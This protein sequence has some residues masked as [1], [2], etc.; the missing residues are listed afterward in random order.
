MLI[1]CP[2]PEC[3]EVLE[4]PEGTAGEHL[5]CPACSKQFLAP[6]TDAPTPRSKLRAERV[7][8]PGKPPT[9]RIP[10]TIVMSAA[11]LERDPLIG[12][13]LGGCLIE[14]K[15]GQGGMGAVYRARHVGLDIDVAVK[16]VPHYLVRRSPQFIDRFQREAR[17]AARLD[18]PNIVKVHNVG[19]DHG[20]HFMVMEFVD[21][22]SLRERL[23]REEELDL[24]TALS[25]FQQVLQALIASHGK[26]IIH[27]DL[28][29]DN[30]LLK[31][32]AREE[33][34]R[35]AKEAPPGGTEPRKTLLVAKLA[36]LGL[37]KV[38]DSESE[39]FTLS[40]VM[41]GTVDYMSPE[42]A[43]DAKSVDERA[44]IY[45]LGC[46]L[47]SML[48]GKKPFPGTTMMQV[49][50]KHVS[51]PFPDILEV[52]PDAPKQIN[53]ML[54]KMTAKQPADRYQ[55]VAEVMDALGMATVG[56]TAEFPSVAP[57]TSAA[58][59]G[60]LCPNC[61]RPYE[62]DAK[63]CSK[64]GRALFEECRRCGENVRAGAA[65]CIH[66]GSNLAEE[67]SIVDGLDLARSLLKEKH[68]NDALESAERIL[69]SDPERVEAQ[70]IRDEAQDLLDRVGELKNAAEVAEEAGNFEDARRSLEKA[71]ELFPGDPELQ[72]VLD[73]LPERARQSDLRTKLVEARLALE[74]QR[75]RTAR[76]LYQ[77]VLAETPGHE[78]ATDGLHACEEILYAIADR[79][80]ELA[81]LLEN[82][83]R[84]QARALCESILEM[85]RDD[86]EAR[87]DLESLGEGEHDQAPAVGEPVPEMDR[88]DL[89]PRQD[90]EVVDEGPAPVDEALSRARVLARGKKWD[91]AVEAW[92]LTLGLS[93]QHAE[94][95]LK[96]HEAR[97]ARDEFERLTA[98]ARRIVEMGDFARA[99]EA[100]LEA[101]KA[102]DWPEGVRILQKVR[103]QGKVVEDRLRGAQERAGGRDWDAA[104]EAFDDVIRDYPSHRDALEGLHQAR[105]ARDVFNDFAH[106]ALQLV[107]ARSLADAE[108]MLRKAHRAGYW[109]ES[110]RLLKQIQDD[111]ARV[112]ALH[113]QAQALIERGESA[114]ALPVL[115]E[116]IRIWP[117]HSACRC[118]QGH[119]SG[120][121]DVLRPNV[122]RARTLLQ[123]NR[124]TSAIEALNATR[125]AGSS[126]D[127][128]E[129]LRQA[130]GRISSSREA[131]AQAEASANDRK[132]RE[133]VKLFEKARSYDEESVS[134]EQ[135]ADARNL[136]APL[137]GQ[138]ELLRGLADREHFEELLREARDA[139]DVGVDDEIDSLCRLAEERLKEAWKKEL[140][141]EQAALR[142]RTKIRKRPKPER[143]AP[144][145]PPEEEPEPPKELTE[146][147]K[148]ARAKL[149]E[150]RQYAARKEWQKTI[151]T[152]EEAL[153]HDFSL[154]EARELVRKAETALSR[155]GIGKIAL[156]VAAAVLA[157]VV[158]AGAILAYRS[159]REV[160][161]ERIAA[162][163]DTQM[164]RAGEKIEAADALFLQAGQELA[165]VRSEGKAERADGAK[166][167]FQ[168]AGKA[169]SA[170]LTLL[171]EARQKVENGPLDEERRKQ[172]DSAFQDTSGKKERAAA[173]ARSSE[174]LLHAFAMFGEC[175]AKGRQLIDSKEMEPGLKA[176]GQALEIGMKSQL[177]E[178]LLKPV[179]EA[180]TK[181]GDLHFGETLNR[182]DALAQAHEWEPAR[183]A[184]AEA[185]RIATETLENA[186]LAEN[187]AV[188]VAAMEAARYTE[189][190]KSGEAHQKAGEWQDARL[191][192]GEAVTLARDVLAREDLVARAQELL[193]QLN[194]DQFNA[195]IQQGDAH[196]KAKRWDEAEAAFL[197]A[198][199]AATEALVDAS[200]ASQA[201]K[202]VEEVRLSRAAAAY[203][204]KLRDGR[205]ELAAGLAKIK[206]A[207]V[208]Q[209]E[210]DETKALAAFT[211]ARE[212]LGKATQSLTEATR[213]A[214]E[215]PLEKGSLS[216]AEAAL[217]EAEQARREIA[218]ALAKNEYAMHL[219][220][221]NEALAE[222]DYQA[223]VEAFA[224]AEAVADESGLDS[225]LAAKQRQLAERL[226]K[227]SREFL[228]G[229]AEAQKLADGKDWNGAAD[230][231]AK[232]AGLARTGELPDKHRVQAQELG[233][234][235][236]YQ[237]K[238]ADAEK[239]EEAGEWNQAIA[240]YQD[241]AE[242]AAEHELGSRYEAEAQA[243]VA[244]I[245]KKLGQLKYRGQ[246]D[247]A[248]ALERQAEEAL[249]QADH[250]AAARAFAAAAAAYRVAETL[251][252]QEKLPEE[253]KRALAAAEE[254][255]QKGKLAEFEARM[256][257][258]RA[259]EQK[260]GQHLAGKAYPDAAESYRSA[261]ELYAKAETYAT[262]SQLKEQAIEASAS[263][264][265]AQQRSLEAEVDVELAKARAFETRAEEKVN[266]A[267]HTEAIKLFAE[268]QTLYEAAAVVAQQKGV[269]EK[270]KQATDK[271]SEVLEK[272][273]HGKFQETMQYA[274]GLAK[275]ADQLAE[276]K[277]YTESA[278]LYLE[279]GREY[280]KAEAYS[281]EQKLP[282]DLTTTAARAARGAEQNRSVQEYELNMAKALEYE[283]A[284][285]W[286]EAQAAY[287]RA[288]G[289]ATKAALGEAR[290]EAASR[291]LDHAT[292]MGGSSRELQT[293]VEQA[294]KLLDE[295]KFK[296]AGA[297]YQKARTVALEGLKN[298]DLARKMGEQ[299]KAVRLAEIDHLIG[300]A[301]GHLDK[302]R[303]AEGRDAYDK[304]KTVAQEEPVLTEQVDL[305]LTRM[306]ELRLAEGK[307]RFRRAHEAATDFEE[308][309]QLDQ[310]HQSFADALT[311]AA[312]LRLP[313]LQRQATT[314]RL[315]AAGKIVDRAKQQ[316][317]TGNRAR[318]Y[319]KA[320]EAYA[321][322]EAIAKAVPLSEE[323]QAELA[324]LKKRTEELKTGWE[325]YSKARAAAEQFL[326]QEEWKEAG[327]SYASALKAA[328]DHQLEDALLETAKKMSQST[329]EMHAA[330][331]R[332]TESLSLGLE[333]EKGERL[334]E[335]LAAYQ[336]AQDLLEKPA[337]RLGAHEAL[338]NALAALGAEA[339]D[340]ITA[341][342]RKIAGASY[343]DLRAK[344]ERFE[345]DLD[346]AKA[347]AA[348]QEAQKKAGAASL[349]QDVVAQVRQ[350]IA[351]AQKMLDATAAYEKHL[352]EGL[353][354][355]GKQ[356]W[357]QARGAYEQALEVARTTPL[358]QQFRDRAETGRADSY[359]HQFEALIRA[360][361]EKEKAEEWLAAM[362]IYEQA[363]DIALKTR[364]A[365]DKKQTVTAMLV[366][367]QPK[368]RGS[369]VYE[370]PEFDAEEAAKRQRETAMALS[371]EPRWEV[372]LEPGVKMA[373]QIIPAGQ[374]LIGS[375]ED[376]KGRDK[377]ES[378]KG[379]G[380]M[381]IRLTK[382][383][384]LGETEV[385]QSQWQV[386]MGHNPSHSK[387]GDDHPVENVSW[388]D[389]EKFLEKLGKVLGRKCRL[390]TEAEWEAACRAGSTTQYWFGDKPQAM[391]QMA[392]YM[393][394]S[395]N[396]DKERRWDEMFDPENPSKKK[397]RVPKVKHS[398]VGT[399]IDYDRGG[400]RTKRKPNPFGLYDMHG[401]LFEWCR[402]WYDEDYFALIGKDEPYLDRVA[403][404]KDRT[405]RGG[406]GGSNLWYCR[407]AE[408]EANDPNEG[409]PDVGLRVLIEIDL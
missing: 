47:Y 289:I 369:L 377:D 100:L 118:L 85:D 280:A 116:A 275:Q 82:G 99:E 51:E 363:R 317:E 63:W 4:A 152:A 393:W 394:F 220:A 184:Y 327:E 131:L 263:A 78:E 206:E 213:V 180:R 34:A 141:A 125:S 112:N 228:A 10:A 179:R 157:V 196:V 331:S 376:E 195:L 398:P 282:P 296:D 359:D 328:E 225:A 62:S 262:D 370:N 247:A 177:S 367:I 345:A 260:A 284:A 22:E 31:E 270:Q 324:A 365:R 249:K 161:I 409:Q 374:Y 215:T 401:N 361:G 334:N 8:D 342:Q 148:K 106:E 400:R 368:V 3:R 295:K 49:M 146:E 160:R 403:K 320:L 139:D 70:T 378:A 302:E 308:K 181:A 105:Q 269:P 57:E 293:L 121:E 26:G 329:S 133:A 305:L 380:P 18:H 307:A 257:L 124:V 164:A 231:Y 120:R 86:D 408:R 42:Q 360:A 309:G 171:E 190:L 153:Q 137:E 217:A 21:G 41:L 98:E 56:R 172:A 126:P 381:R 147:E 348:L 336:Q 143:K 17:A 218:A 310:A 154:N 382:P 281:E 264:G 236:G 72:E 407:S 250:A 113:A 149:E 119:V 313:E 294:T 332:F 158:L 15:L 223:A 357:D 346:W 268:A 185:R 1:R 186:A 301:Q 212:A 356:D 91:D 138:A 278:A 192:F 81:E 259:A 388:I 322:A 230:A 30:I 46:T 352:N 73:G 187:V 391:R 290:L 163:F 404:P 256:A 312:E 176:L 111:Q 151:D 61:G 385:T 234:Q 79:K 132:W 166:T 272:Q 330:K 266:E 188:S 355:E 271:A 253:Q 16:V 396:A 306:E 69:A 341:V 23:E 67:T 406:A 347:L 97:Q 32:V 267:R 371:L 117:G 372:E 50:L 397:G 175:A 210:E 43:E 103:V 339:G 288:K 144:P 93:P 29:P 75:P 94:A 182:A 338:K 173:E 323:V 107:E 283:A 326:A 12:M 226:E 292:A 392:T 366:R 189:I 276:K 373:F 229:M 299:V 242:F 14:S 156:G 109:P 319:Q 233:V 170:A 37:A 205:A 2:N 145:P 246:I 258:A 251:A 203:D 286:A 244:E 248:E 11:E 54:Q 39:G 20:L 291:E 60:A 33:G 199:K 274:T 83:E 314:G 315:R 252:R 74:D 245:E 340:R 48:S 28:K 45:S 222:E 239:N 395:F 375:K 35:E 273:H 304:A 216:E 13:E 92:E 25:I 77:A 52:R 333:H 114:Q 209:Q 24:E 122:E 178:L 84:D 115:E 65:F 159:H 101:L 6:S 64:C 261:K 298:Q 344:A 204:Q 337:P 335:A 240:A 123:K 386:V 303:W 95:K 59:T 254:T 110:Q 194:L 168:N 202:R 297:I 5:R 136:A 405:V 191:A 389:C 169:Y 343:E 71:L 325:K 265:Q 390:P 208:H 384:Y 193:K 364:D 58:E 362:K 200:L 211:A 55:S 358:D 53:E 108:C 7:S 221:G 300:Q 287:A 279:A 90:P 387:L 89:E 399:N 353:E 350:A 128:E 134:L 201:D 36:D 237:A 227:A 277:S 150:A 379:Q 27:R 127:T 354:H 9:E 207:Q 44:D 174:E 66:C 224:K 19:Q 285:E 165:D 243:K 76:P 129:L 87:Q 183:K 130:Q 232:A 255:A 241:A 88:E 167:G 155:R 351:R 316:G 214:R 383:Y 197:A 318:E 311:I 142:E 198:K 104:I 40:G 68:V 235:A 321:A 96:L 219:L 238:K 102:G 38:A 402:D 80:T 140:E 135:L 349:S 162:E